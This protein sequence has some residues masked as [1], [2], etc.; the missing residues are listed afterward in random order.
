MQLP[1]LPSAAR[2]T[3][4][5]SADILVGNASACHLI[6]DVTSAGTGSVTPK[7]QGKDANGVYYDIIVGA[8]LTSNGTNVLKVGRGFTPSAN[9]VVTDILPDVIRVVHTHNNS[10]SITYSSSLN[11]KI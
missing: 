7:L 8:A 6:T 9:A 3:T 10:N 4:V 5:T 11:T 1:V 2:T